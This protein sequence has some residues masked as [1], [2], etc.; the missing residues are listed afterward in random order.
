MAKDVV[1]LEKYYKDKVDEYLKDAPN[2]MILYSD[3]FKARGQ[4][5]RT[6]GTYFAYIV[7][8]LEYMD[9]DYGIDCRDVDN[10]RRIKQAHIYS[11]LKTKDETA[12]STRRIV[13][14]AIKH[15]FKYLWEN[16]FIETDPALRVR[17]PKDRKVHQVTALTND[18]IRMM[19]ERIKKGWHKPHIG[20]TEPPARK[21]Y[22]ITRDLCM[23]HLAIKTGLRVSEICGLDVNDV[24]LDAHTMRFI[25]KGGDERIVSIPSSVVDEIEDWLDVRPK[26]VAIRK[27]GARKTNALFLSN[28]GGRISISQFTVLV[29]NWSID[30]D[31]HITPHKLRSTFATHFYDA[32]KNIY[33]TAK[34]LNHKNIKTT[35]RYLSVDEKELKVGAD[36]ADS[37]FND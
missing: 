19:D 27:N 14:Y 11:F 28:K 25:E 16:E 2:Y 29:E 20:E 35:M 7:E 18:E 4:S 21:P 12:D 9:T 23:F 24:D 26:L 30:V 22:L 3:E 1:T 17:P 32:T 37:M 5:I 15:F 31:K 6:E 33:L 34:M 8:F 13:T 10:L 36:V